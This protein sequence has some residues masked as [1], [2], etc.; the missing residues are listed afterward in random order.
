M[1]KGANDVVDPVFVLHP[2]LDLRTRGAVFDFF[3]GQNGRVTTSLQKGAT[4]MEVKVNTVP[5]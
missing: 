4:T 3:H 1:K 2:S 5:L